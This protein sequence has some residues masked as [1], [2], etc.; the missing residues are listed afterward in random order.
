MKKIFENDLLT[1]ELLLNKHI[2]IETLHILK[3]YGINFNLKNK[4]NNCPVFQIVFFYAESSKELADF[5]TF[6]IN[7]KISF[8]DNIDSDNFNAIRYILNIN[9]NKQYIDENVFNSSDLL[10]MIL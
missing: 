8:V 4:K 10:N 2:N 5:I 9:D 3:H 6:F 1:E 7:E